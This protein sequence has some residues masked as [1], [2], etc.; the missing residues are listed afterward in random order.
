MAMLPQKEAKEMLY[1][2]VAEHMVT[3]Q[4]VPKSQDYAPARTFYLFSV[5]LQQVARV[6]LN[7]CYKAVG[8]LIV[9][10]RA[11]REEHRWG[12]AYCYMHVT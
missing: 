6:L 12:V 4:E 8:N 10:R 1:T 11:E 3:I 2:L 7:R 9:K 5:N